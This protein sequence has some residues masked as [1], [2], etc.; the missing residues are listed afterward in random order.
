MN[1]RYET[2]ALALLQKANNKGSDLQFELHSL[3]LVNFFEIKVNKTQS[4]ASDQFK[5]CK[6]TGHH[7][8]ILLE[9]PLRC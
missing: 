1:S 2:M 3:D 7:S 6:A 5:K 9:Q 4:M 8:R